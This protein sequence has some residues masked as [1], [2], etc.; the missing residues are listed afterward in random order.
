MSGPSGLVQGS[1]QSTVSDPSAAATGSEVPRIRDPTN[2]PS[3]RQGRDEVNPRGMPHHSRPLDESALPRSLPV[4]DDFTVQQLR[5]TV[6]LQEA[7]LHVYQQTLPTVQS[8]QRMLE[9]QNDKLLRCQKNTYDLLFIFKEVIDTV[10]SFVPANG[11]PRPSTSDHHGLDLTKPR[12]PDRPFTR[13]GTAQSATSKPQELRGSLAPASMGRVEATTD[14]TWLDKSDN[15]GAYLLHTTQESSDNP[16]AS[17][18]HPLSV[19][20][21]DNDSGDETEEEDWKSMGAAALLRAAL[22]SQSHTG[23]S[24]EIIIFERR[25]NILL[26]K[27]L[28]I[29]THPRLPERTPK[30]ARCAIRALR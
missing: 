29:H 21:P 4:T 7:Q 8:L 26:T 14:K 24:V 23:K 27:S 20:I 6:A 9:T 2:G 1:R 13:I 30:G 22:P 10:V 25:A 5:Q 3:A 19:Q 17:A 18:S 11:V 16:S 12:S 15:L 28:S